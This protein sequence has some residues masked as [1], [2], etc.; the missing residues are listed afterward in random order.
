MTKLHKLWIK[1]RSIGLGAFVMSGVLIGVGYWLDPS[2][3]GYVNWL[4]II[5]FSVGLIGLF[6]SLNDIEQK[7]EGLVGQQKQRELAASLTEAVLQVGE[8]TND[9]NRLDFE[10]ITPSTR[11]LRDHLIRLKAR[12]Q[13]EHSNQ[14]SWTS[15]LDIYIDDLSEIIVNLPVDS[16]R[17]SLDLIP[18]RTKLDNIDVFLTAQ[19]SILSYGNTGSLP[20]P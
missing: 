2:N 5:G 7:V 14:G 17:D 8:T 1:Y 3:M 4:G 11:R 6:V 18:I 19:Q 13:S 20:N 16:S 10:R 15:K 12:L 9:F